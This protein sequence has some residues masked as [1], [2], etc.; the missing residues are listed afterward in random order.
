MVILDDA[1]I[2]L[3]VDAA[4]YGSFFHQGQIC[5][6]ANR[7]VV[8]THVNDQFVNQFVERVRA[9]RVGD[10][11]DPAT[12]IGPII[13]RGQLE[14]IQDKLTRARHAG[15]TVLVGGEAVGPVGLSLPPHVLLGSNDVATAREEVFGPVITIIR[16]DNEAHALQIANDTELGLSSSVFTRDRERGVRFALRIEAGMTH[17]NDSPVND[18]PNTAFGGEKAS[19]IGRFGGTWAVDESTT[20]H[21]ISIQHEP[22]TYSI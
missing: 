18:D 3:A 9:L 7:L 4:V 12:D 5:V 22:R 14:S 10:P 19:G 11:S 6:I 20:D 13:N 21:W 1:D 17:I 16:S 2:D 8:D 15:A